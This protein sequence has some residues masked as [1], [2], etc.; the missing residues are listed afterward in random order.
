M[1]GAAWRPVAHDRWNGLFK[2]TCFHNL[3]SSGQ[4]DNVAGGVLDYVQKSHV[5]NLT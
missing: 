4:V 5:L 2:Y 1:L 3:P